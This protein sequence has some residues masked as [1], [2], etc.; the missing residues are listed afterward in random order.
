VVVSPFFILSTIATGFM[1]LAPVNGNRLILLLHTPRKW[2]VM[3]ASW[4][5]DESKKSAMNQ[6]KNINRAPMAVF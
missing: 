1:T 2:I 3:V 4:A 6:N 5:W